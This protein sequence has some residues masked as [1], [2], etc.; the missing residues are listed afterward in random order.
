M[1]RLLFLALL[2]IGALV[3]VL[4]ATSVGSDN[5]KK[6]DGKGVIVELDGYKSR[7]PAE[8]K[9][10]APGN[11]MRLTQFRLP[12]AEGDKTDAELVVFKGIGGSAKAN[13]DRWK[14]FFIPPE[15]KTIDDIAKVTEIKMS[16]VDAPYLDVKGT[17]KFKERPFDPNSKEERK[18]DYRMLGVV[19]ETKK[20]P[21]H[22]RLVGPAKTV[23]KYKKDFDLW[24]KGF[25]E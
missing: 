15:G 22:I 11:Q 5:D 2:G 21:Y 18:P 12:K 16:D 8:W 9:E 10:E 7:A 23:E 4:P 25:R 1:K 6:D 24:L 3:L 14:G 20:N 13:I 17:Y 19:F